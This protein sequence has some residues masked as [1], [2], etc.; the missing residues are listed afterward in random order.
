[1]GPR[2]AVEMLVVPDCPNERAA[3]ELI[4]T[5]LADVHLTGVDVTKSIIADEPEAVRRGFVGSPT[6]LLNGHDPFAQPGARPAM[7]C[8]VYQTPDGPHGLPALTDLRAA[9]KRAA[10]WSR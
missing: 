4:V 7:A 10:D 6:F 1:M 2:L 5:A 8:R 3:E 9:L